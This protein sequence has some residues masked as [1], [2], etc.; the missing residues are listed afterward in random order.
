[1][2]LQPLSVIS[3]LAEAREQG[4][5][6]GEE[7]PIFVRHGIVHEGEKIDPPVYHPFLELGIRFRG[8]G[9]LCIEGQILRRRPY[10]VFLGSIGLPHWGTV[11]RYPMEFVSV[12]F[13]PSVFSDWG[14]QE[15]SL[16]I[17]NRFFAPQPPRNRLVRPS[18]ELRQRLA[19]GFREMAAEFE[20]E[21]FGRRFK[22]QSLLIGMLVDLLRWE[23][24]SGRALLPNTSKRE[25]WEKVILA[26]RYVRQHFSEPVYAPEVAAAAG[27]S[28]T[29]LK[30]A[31]QETIQMPW[32]RYLQSYRI[33]RASLLLREHSR[34]VTEVALAVGFQ[35]LSHFNRTFK[36][37]T[38]K[39]PGE[40]GKIKNRKGGTK[41]PSRA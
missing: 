17:L 7:F 33:H 18:P 21:Q 19:S 23:K 8:E 13:L 38:G 9:R 2:T 35:S 15:E 1:M 25:Q 29:R 3:S 20:S 34:N 11:E 39:T 22:Q 32:V 41:I 24:S 14:N 12:Y 10:D 37:F 4:V 6:L 28:V 5:R 30:I 31:F 26:M 36:V 27:V 40:K 16:S